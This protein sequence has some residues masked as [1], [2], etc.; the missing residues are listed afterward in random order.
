MIAKLEAKALN[1]DEISVKWDAEALSRRGVKSIRLVAQP[2]DKSL[3]SL[4]TNVS[5]SAGEAKITDGVM[6]STNYTIHVEDAD[7]GGFEYSIGEIETMPPGGLSRCRF[8]VTCI[9]LISLH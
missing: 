6:P 8:D 5:T 7:A 2:M 9:L 3:P 4:D 1:T